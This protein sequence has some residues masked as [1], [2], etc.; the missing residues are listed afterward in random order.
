M[1]VWSNLLSSGIV[2]NKRYTAH[3]ATLVGKDWNFR[4]LSI[5]NF[6]KVFICPLFKAK[7]PNQITALEQHNIGIF[8]SILFIRLWC[9]FLPIT[10]LGNSCK[11]YG[12]R[13]FN[14]SVIAVGILYFQSVSITGALL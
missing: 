1:L 8:Y 9:V 7:L 4:R 11:Q 13:L 3:V 12:G 14:S 2:P 5:W 6:D 10:K